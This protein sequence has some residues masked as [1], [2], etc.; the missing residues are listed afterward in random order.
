[1]LTGIALGA[2]LLPCFGAELI[3]PPR[4]ATAKSVI[5]IWVWGGPS[6]LE[7]F[8]PKPDAPKDYSN[9]LK[10]IPTNVPGVKISELLP[11]LAQQADKY[12]IIRSMTH[13]HRGHET[14]TYLMQTGREPGGG[15]VF[16]AIGAVIAM[17]KSNEYKGDISPYVILTVAKGRFSEVGFLNASYSPLVTGGNPSQTRFVVDG[18]VPPGGASAAE[19]ARRMNM[20]RGLDQFGDVENCCEELAKFKRSGERAV[21]IIGGPAAKVFDLSEETDAMRDKYGRNNF[22]QSCLVARRLVEA[23]VPYITLNAQGWDSHKRHFETMKQRTAEMDQAVAALLEDLSS[24]KL[25]DTTLIWWSGE[26]GRSPKI[27]WEAPWNGGRN[28][29]SKCFSAMVAGGG[30]VGGKVVGLS[31]ANAENVVSRPVEPQ[32]LLGSIYELCGID[33]D[34]ELPNPIGLK[35]PVLP[36]E[37]K[38]GRLRELYRMDV[39]KK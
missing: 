13:P 26:F 6:Q 27:D 33:P 38:T 18:I 9:G 23:G 34:S 29:Y 16:P 24:R 37:S 30:F 31:D 20:L 21:D 28:H 3:K 11:K 39:D 5:E 1:M 32:D 17:F 35:E 8:D 15:F 22:G 10:A 7:T 2:L 36:P 4:R 12:S 25:L 14:A 19:T